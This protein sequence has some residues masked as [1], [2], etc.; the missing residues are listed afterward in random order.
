[1]YTLQSFV[2][3]A[4]LVRIASKIAVVIMMTITT[5]HTFARVIKKLKPVIQE[6]NRKAMLATAEH[7]V[8]F[9]RLESKK[10]AIKATIRIVIIQN[11]SECSLA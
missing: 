8:I 4:Y 9:P 5:A 2:I 7:A 11:M 10:V 1:M 3:K 6:S